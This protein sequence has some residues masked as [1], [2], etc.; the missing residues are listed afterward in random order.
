MSVARRGESGAASAYS[1]W[2]LRQRVQYATR[3][4]WAAAARAFRSCWTAAATR[5]RWAVAARPSPPL[6]AALGPRRGLGGCAPPR[7]HNARLFLPL[8]C[9]PCQAADRRH[10]EDHGDPDRKHFVQQHRFASPVSCGNQTTGLFSKV[11][12]PTRELNAIAIARAMAA[13]SSQM[14]PSSPE[15]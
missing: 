5:R 8:P 4:R 13:S 10:D 6:R 7:P 1:Y 14:A 12:L 15:L 11:P 9:P 2:S 3:R